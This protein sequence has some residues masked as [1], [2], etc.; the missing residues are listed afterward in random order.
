MNRDDAKQ[1]IRSRWR[2]IMPGITEPAKS[3]MNGEQSWICPICKHGANG[4]GLTFDPRSADGNELKCFGGSCSFSH[5]DI[6]TLYRQYSGAD[7][8]TALHQLADML[9]ITIDRYDP[10][11][12]FTPLPEDGTAGQA[13]R[14]ETATGNINTRP[15]GSAATEPQNAPRQNNAGY[16][17][18][19]AERIS[20]PAALAYLAKRGLSEETARRYSIGFDPAADPAKAPGGKGKPMHPA[21][22]LI[23]P[24][25]D[26]YYVARSIAD[27]ATVKGERVVNGKT[28]KYD[29]RKMNPSGAESGIF[30]LQALY[31]PDVQEVFITEAAIDALSIIEAGADAIG[32]NSANNARKLVAQLE[33]KQ[34]TATLILAFDNDQSGNYARD[35]IAATCNRL[36][37]SFII[38]NVCG[39]C[40][41]ANE[42]LTTDR[43]AFIDAVEEA[44]SRTAAKP[45]SIGYYIDHLMPGEIERFHADKKTGFPNLDEKSGGLYAG[46]YCVA[47]ISSLGKTTF[48]HQM[49][50][51]LAAAGHDVVFFS[52]E[53]SRLELVSKSIARKTAQKDIN[54]A[55]TSLAIRGGYMPEQVRTA[56][57]EYAQ[58]VQDRL[59]I[60]E[61]NYNCNVS[62]IGDY[63]RQYIRR[64]GVVPVLVIDYLQ[65]LQPGN[66]AGKQTTK[67]IVDTSITEL[68][69]LSRELEM[70]VFVIS[71]VNRANYLTPIDFESLKE[72]GNIEY[73][74]DVI[75][76]LQLQCLNRE[77]FD[78]AK[79][80]IK[81]QREIVREAKAAIPRKIEL[82]CLKNRFG[83]SSYSCYFDYDPRYDLFTVCPD[84]LLDFDAEPP[85]KP[86]AQ[87]KRR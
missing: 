43:Q 37:I 54:K 60:V 76:G 38:G 12:D 15:A 40:K 51:Q 78:K 21:P 65:V 30:N 79:N 68:K 35:L 87:Q 86:T 47:A 36:N 73:T 34:P 67:E 13:R 50:D 3:R 74:A 20:D 75:W 1:I 28:V 66:D 83:I 27:D 59:S 7:Y 70:T 32:T 26:E 52:L 46:L 9:G 72:S 10:R 33:R 77:D 55:V 22:R 69:R 61:G 14:N 81:A 57:K 84:A 5:G 6:I 49:C 11:N 53:Q 63:V 56:R 71:S 45:D 8:N 2:D 31:A 39:S 42:A 44:Q 64:N 80:N 82:V 58:E 23:I 62:F 48:T 19:C 41:D 24:V 85:M 17:R 4:D 16:Y 18:I 29:Y 25:T